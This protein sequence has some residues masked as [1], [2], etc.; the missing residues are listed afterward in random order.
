M[1][2]YSAGTASIPGLMKMSQSSAKQSKS[3][4][5]EL[6]VQEFE[7]VEGTWFGLADA[8]STDEAK[9]NGRWIVM[10]K[11]HSVDLTV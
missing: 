2:G 11:A 10:D 9:N 8:Q 4:V 7:T 5:S 3:N 6:M 1:T